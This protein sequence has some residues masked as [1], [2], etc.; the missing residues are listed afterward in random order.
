[1]HM[2]TFLEMTSLNLNLHDYIVYHACLVKSGFTVV[3]ILI[4][5]L[6]ISHELACM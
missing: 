3:N 6:V 4:H 5:I 1:M 2:Y